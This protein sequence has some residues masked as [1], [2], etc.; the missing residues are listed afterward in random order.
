MLF[1]VLLF[2]VNFYGHWLE[3]RKKGQSLKGG[4]R[5]PTRRS[6]V[7]RT[8]KDSQSGALKWRSQVALTRGTRARAR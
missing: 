7:L 3:R 5:G 2:S 6:G 8:A 1:Q 4:G